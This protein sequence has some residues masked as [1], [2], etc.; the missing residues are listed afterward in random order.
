VFK[1]FVVEVYEK[2][3]YYGQEEEDQMDHNEKIPVSTTGR[4]EAE[5]PVAI[6]VDPLDFSSPTQAEIPN[7][8]A[9]FTPDFGDFQ[10]APTTSVQFLPPSNTNN[11]L[12]PSFAHTSS[13]G[14]RIQNAFGSMNA[15]TMS[16]N[17]NTHH[18][19]INNGLVMNT[20]LGTGM[21]M[22]A[23][24]G[25]MNA[26]MNGINSTMNRINAMNTKMNAMN[27]NN[28]FMPKN[29]WNNSITGT[30][31]GMSNNMPMYNATKMG[32]YV[33]YG[34]MSNATTNGMSMNNGMTMGMNGGM[35]MNNGTNQI[36]GGTAINSG[37][38]MAS[39]TAQKRDP[40]ADFSPFS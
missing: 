19:P 11:A 10:S 2:R 6:S 14:M 20:G 18:L 33:S 24:N 25:S 22:N 36:N 8:S 15:C 16:M 1:A 39:S 37:I 27:G 38:N 35:G 31:N 29:S 9:V 23:M 21:T 32:N 3:S 40:F 5:A 12:N 4:A 13:S 17:G 30:N 7:V 28:H 26:T 34:V